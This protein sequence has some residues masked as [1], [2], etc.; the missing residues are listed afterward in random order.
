MYNILCVV[1]F[2]RMCVL[3]RI[4]IDICHSAYDRIGWT[5]VVGV[6]SPFPPLNLRWWSLA[7]HGCMYDV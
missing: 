7:S 3:I 5:G 6:G 2:V 1:R 4:R